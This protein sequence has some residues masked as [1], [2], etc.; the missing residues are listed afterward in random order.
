V[1]WYGSQP[2]GRIV[3]A[4]AT[5]TK[6]GRDEAVYEIRLHGRGGQGVVLASGILA[7]GLVE[8][9]KYAVA[10]PSFG[11]ERRSAASSSNGSRFRQRASG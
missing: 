1:V 11:F 5:A 2:N 7:T 3:G 8:A 6:Q 4:V 9:G 10:I